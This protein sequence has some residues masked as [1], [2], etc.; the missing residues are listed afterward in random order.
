MK[1]KTIRDSF[2]L[3]NQVRIPCIGFGTYKAAEGESAQVLRMA[4]DAGYRYFDTASFYDTER[5]LAQAIAESRLPRQEFFLASKVWKTQMG[6]HETQR[7][8]QES[9]ETLRTDYLDLYLIHWP[10]REPDEEGWEELDADTW[11]AMEEAYEAGTVRAIGV[12][13]FLPHHLGSLLARARVRPMVDQIEFHP[14]YL[15]EET[16]R[17]CQAREILVQAWSP[18]GRARVLNDPLL[19]SLAEAHQVSPAQ[20]C[21]RFAL[22][23]GVLPLPKASSTERMKQNQQVFSFALTEE[24]M[25]RLRRMPQT[26]WSGEHPDRERVMI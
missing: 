17:C 7:A 10:K 12:S 24:E 23:T 11:R 25:E 5:F 4:I 26:G 3:Y 13:N 1:Q 16:V 20:I 9:L 18:L 15:Q 19:L 22:Q 21:L 14:G 8:L 6:Y 2:T